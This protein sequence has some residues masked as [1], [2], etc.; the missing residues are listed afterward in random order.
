MLWWSAL[1]RSGC[2][3]LQDRSCSVLSHVVAIDLA[4]SRLEAAKLFGADITVNNSREDPIEIIRNLTDGLGADVAIEAVGTPATFELATELV[5]PG[6]EVVATSVYTVNLPPSIW[7]RSGL[8]MSRSPRVLSTPIRP[9]PQ[10]AHGRVLSML[11][12][13]THHSNSTK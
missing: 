6:G 13:L 4:D 11:D 2:R 5:K 9:R 3:R 7:K 1:D 10:L 12:D 8:E